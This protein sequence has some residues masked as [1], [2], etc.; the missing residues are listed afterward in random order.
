MPTNLYGPGDNFNLKDSHVLPALIRKVHEAKERGDKHMEIW[1]TGN[2]RREFL[3]VDDMADA[4]M[5][6]MQN[7]E[8]NGWINVGWGRDISIAEL[9]KL[10]AKMI[11]Y[12]GEMRFNTS[13]PDGTAQKLLDTARL[14]ALGW[15]PKIRLEIGIEETYRWFLSNPVRK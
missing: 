7:Y 9:A 1:G 5:F 12:S 4:C 10:I 13:M 2:P 15:K 8:G 6:L 11:G 3:H 14:S